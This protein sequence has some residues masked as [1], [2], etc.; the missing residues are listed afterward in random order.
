MI[1]GSLDRLR[2][3]A[4]SVLQPRNVNAWPFDLALY[5]REGGRGPWR[6]PSAWRAPRKDGARTRSR[7]SRERCHGTIPP[8]SEPMKKVNT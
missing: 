1:I 6:A 7:D 3:T 2:F 8:P 4:W 5:R